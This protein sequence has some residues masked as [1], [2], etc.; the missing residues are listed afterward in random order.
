MFV[1]PVVLALGASTVTVVEVSHCCWSL[2]SPPG[3]PLDRP[4]NEGS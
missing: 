2:A 1:S 4:G 3:S